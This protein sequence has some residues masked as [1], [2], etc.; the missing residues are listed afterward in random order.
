[1]LNRHRPFT[2]LVALPG[3]QA[4]L[5]EL[6]LYVAKACTDAPRFGAVKLNKIIWKADFDSFAERGVPV[7]GRAYK[8]QKLGPV[9]HE[10]VSVLN[11]MLR[12]GLIQMRQIDL[13]EGYIEHRTIAARE[14]EL[15]LFGFD[16]LAYVQRAIE[17]YWSMTGTESS[18]ESHGVAWRTRKNGDPMPYEAALLSDRQPGAAQMA[19]L[20][21]LIESRKFVS[22]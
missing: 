4:R 5:R 21:Q 11:E 3:G 14:P 6:I 10:M 15:G 17:H 16:D 8:R 18:D 22:L 12:D 20:T 2:A 13:G 7:T 1:M 19:R 9:L